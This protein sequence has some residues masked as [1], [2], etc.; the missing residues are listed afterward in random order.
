[1]N[2]NIFISTIKNIIL[3]TIRKIDKWQYFLI[4]CRHGEKELRKKYYNNEKP[5]KTGKEPV[6]I[7]M[8]N[9]Y[10]WHGGLSDRLKGAITVYNWCKN[11]QKQFKI[12]WTS[13]FELNRYIVPNQ[14]NW[15]IKKEDVVYSPNTTIAYVMYNKNIDKL[16]QNGKAFKLTNHYFDKKIASNRNQAHIYT[17]AGPNDN[18]L[19][20]RLFNELFKPS[21][22]IEKELNKHWAVIKKRD[23]ISVSFRFVQL[24]GDFKDSSGTILENS[25]RIKLINKSLNV[26]DKLYNK[27]NCHILVTADS[28]TFLNEAKKRKYVYVAEGRVGHIDFESS[29]EVNIK[30]FVDF[31]LIANAKKVYLAKSNLMYNSDFA[32]RASMLNNLEFKLVEY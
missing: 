12:N 29:D 14:Y 26:L 30:T 28:S 23:Y 2:K 31:Y 8:V 22:L 9:G 7:F 5:F 24:L 27:N 25:E 4:E 10:S 1:M 13:P 16:I 15:L 18:I 32:R 17:N 20:G 21:E 19:F 11:N 6:Y 3:D